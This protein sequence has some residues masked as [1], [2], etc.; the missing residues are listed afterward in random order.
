GLVAVGLAGWFVVSQMTGHNPPVSAFFP[1]SVHESPKPEYRIFH[2]R[3]GTFRCR[4]DHL[5]STGKRPWNCIRIHPP[6]KAIKPS[7]PV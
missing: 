2:W 7:P 5:N 6:K 4:I 3:N 1:A